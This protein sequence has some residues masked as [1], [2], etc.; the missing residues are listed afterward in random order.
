MI[1]PSRA[2]AADDPPDR[3]LRRRSRKVQEI[4]RATSDVIAERGY[5]LASLEDIALRLDVTKA[6]LYYYFPSKDELILACLEWVAD[7]VIARLEVTAAA[8]F[9]SQRER[10]CALVAVQM[11]EVCL[12]HPHLSAFFLHPPDLP[13]A[14]QTQTK[15]LRR[16]HDQVFRNVVEAG[17]E[18]GEFQTVVLGVAMNNLYGAMNFAPHWLTVRPRRVFNAQV[19]EMANNLLLLFSPVSESLR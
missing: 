6:S 11:E 17:I 14:L 16:R 8:P 7:K 15:S 1:R 4:L 2:E 5:Q 10:L 19:A 18:T 12:K 9:E 13:R 3:V